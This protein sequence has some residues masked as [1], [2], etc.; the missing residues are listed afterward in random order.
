M[1]AFAVKPAG[2]SGA[3]NEIS[4]ADLTGGLAEAGLLTYALAGAATVAVGAY[5]F[6]NQDELGHTGATFG[7]ALGAAKH[8]VRVNFVDPF[9]DAVQENIIAPISLQ[10]REMIKAAGAMVNA[11]KGRTPVTEEQIKEASKE[12]AKQA[13]K[14]GQPVT[15]EIAPNVK[16]KQFPPPS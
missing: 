7:E 13:K 16:I 5:Y 14:T 15:I 4:E 3:Y 12:A 1:S 10:A 2:V 11:A 9:K 6:A 8:D